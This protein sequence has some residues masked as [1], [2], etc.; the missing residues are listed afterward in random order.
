MIF[1]LEIFILV[2]MLI[3]QELDK[4]IG[5]PLI[6]FTLN[7]KYILYHQKHCHSDVTRVK[8]DLLEASI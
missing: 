5:A 7:T 6:V 4:K 1:L 8:S 3:R 2:K